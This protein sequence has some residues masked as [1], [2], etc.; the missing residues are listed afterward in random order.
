M[1]EQ[2]KS[3]LKAFLLD[4]IKDKDPDSAT[5]ALRMMEDLGWLQDGSLSGADFRKAN[6]PIYMMTNSRLIDFDLTG[7]DFSEAYLREVNFCS[8]LLIGAKFTKAN[9]KWVWFDD[10][11]L[12][13]AVFNQANLEGASIGNYLRGAT[14]VEAQASYASFSGDL[15]DVSFQHTNLIGALF[16][17]ADLRGAD[18]TEANLQGVRIRD[19]HCD[20][21]TILPNGTRWKAVGDWAYFTDPDH[22]DFWRSKDAL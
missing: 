9:M 2:D 8:S 20:N 12:E 15:Q 17:Q 5:K 11:H 10:A 14:F 18:F 16:V 21:T 6:L 1:T 22:P 3:Q 7:V 13:N 4:Q 19:C